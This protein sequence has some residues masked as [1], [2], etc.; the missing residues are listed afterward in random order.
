MRL[1]SIK[2][3]TTVKRDRELFQDA[4][5][6]E[7]EET[8]GALI[9]NQKRSAPPPQPPIATSYTTTTSTPSAT[10]QKFRHRQSEQ[11]VLEVRLKEKVLSSWGRLETLRP[12]MED[13]NPEDVQQWMSIA[14]ELIDDFRSIRSFFPVE[15]GKRITW[16]DEDSTKESSVVGRKRKFSDI[17]SRVEEIE[18]R[19]QQSM[20]NTGNISLPCGADG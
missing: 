15:K 2:S 17:E 14:K 7:P 16:Y 20:E 4:E 18:T 19:L 9:P 12:G 8:T 3:L 11:I 1:A 5:I 10:R 13:G 6:A